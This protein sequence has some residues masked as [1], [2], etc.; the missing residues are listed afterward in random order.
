M[1]EQSAQVAPVFTP[2]QQRLL[3]LLSD[4]MPHTRK[5]LVKCLDDELT[6]LDTVNVHISYLRRKLRPIG[7]DIICEMGSS[8]KLGYRHVRLLRSPV[9]GHS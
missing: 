1:S 6:S 9:D 5:E 8:Y 3:K 4:G 2:T 7:Q